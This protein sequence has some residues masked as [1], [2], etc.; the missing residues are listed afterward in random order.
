MDAIKEL[1]DFSNFLD[2]RNNK[3]NKEIEN[4]KKIRAEK[5]IKEIK[6]KSLV[7][8]IYNEKML[9]NLEIMNEKVKSIVLPKKTKIE[10]E[11]GVHMDTHIISKN[12]EYALINNK[13]KDIY[14][15]KI[16]YELIYRASVDGAFGK[17][18]KKKCLN[19][20][21]TLIVVQSKKNKIFG[22]FTEVRWN[23]SNS[24]Y[25]DENAFCFSLDEN[26]IYNSIKDTKAISCQSDFGPMFCDMFEITDNFASDGGFS[27]RL[28][29]E[30]TKYDG[31]TKDYEL[32]GEEL[33]KIKELEVF[34][35][36]IE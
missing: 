25:K 15:S 6:S 27:K 34:K 28:G 13:L 8:G 18:F 32:P 9:E 12:S 21:R 4:N 3:K 33:F 22:G 26:K 19:V 20:R 7:I 35:V 14:K 2:K 1:N 29:L 24:D 23:D 11:T 31:V 17:I 10:K 36:K 5:M 30:M 16:Q